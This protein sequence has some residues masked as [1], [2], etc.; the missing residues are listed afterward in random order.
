MSSQLLRECAVSLLALILTAISLCVSSFQCNHEVLTRHF[1]YANARQGSV[2]S[3]AFIQAIVDEGTT[4]LMVFR[5]VYFCLNLYHPP[6]CSEAVGDVL[7]DVTLNQRL[8]RDAPRLG[9]SGHRA[10]I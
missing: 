9:T 4:N 10:A 6:P 3:F 5:V 8:L 7:E 2:P 1:V